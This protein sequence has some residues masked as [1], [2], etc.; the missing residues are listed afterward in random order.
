MYEESMG[1]ISPLDV[2]QMTVDQVLI[3]W[4]KATS[5]PVPMSASQAVAAGV[6]IDHAA[7]TAVEQAQEI[8]AK[9]QQQWQSKTQSRLEKRREKRKLRRQAEQD[10]LLSGKDSG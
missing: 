5:S 7:K 6:E 2:A 3:C 8:L 4:D 10:Q 9:Q 1:R